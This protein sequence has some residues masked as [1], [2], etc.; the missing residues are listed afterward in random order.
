MSCIG[1]L[2]DISL[3]YCAKSY[4]KLIKGTQSSHDT[5]QNIW[6]A[7]QYYEQ[8]NKIYRRTHINCVLRANV[9]FAV[10]QCR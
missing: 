3:F 5:G 2:H 4:Y 6:V 8:L 7:T 10:F 1:S 9:F